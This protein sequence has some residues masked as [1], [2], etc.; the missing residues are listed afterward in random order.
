MHLMLSSH[1]NCVWIIFKSS[2]YSKNFIILAITFSSP[3]YRSNN[4]S[5]GYNWF[6]SSLTIVL[7]AVQIFKYKIKLKKVRRKDSNLWEIFHTQKFIRLQL[8]HRWTY[9]QL[10]ETQKSNRSFWRKEIPLSVRYLNF[11]K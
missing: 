9:R 11:T 10:E 3:F 4:N 6:N 8:N 2:V 7:T 5:H 1:L